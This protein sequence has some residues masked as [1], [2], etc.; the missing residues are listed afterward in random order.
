M[1]KRKTKHKKKA[2]PLEASSLDIALHLSRY[3]DVDIVE[4]LRS[5]S[6]ETSCDH[7][8]SPGASGSNETRDGLEIPSSMFRHNVWGFFL[9]KKEIKA[10]S[11]SSVFKNNLVFSLSIF[12][13]TFTYIN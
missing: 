10:A 9:N 12:R 5:E 13:F 1:I 6:L 7:Y 2:I 4:G 11:V 8:G 3:P